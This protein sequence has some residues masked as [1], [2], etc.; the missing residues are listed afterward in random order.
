MPGAS[1]DPIRANFLSNLSADLG[2]DTPY[3]F[4][5]YLRETT[6]CKSAAGNAYSLADIQRAEGGKPAGEDSAQPIATMDQIEAAFRTAPNDKLQGT[7]ELATAILESV[8]AIDVVV[9]S[10]SAGATGINFSGLTDTLTQILDV[11]RPHVGGVDDLKSK[12]VSVD[13]KRIASEKG[14]PLTSLGGIRSR[15]DA[16]AVLAAVC[17]YFK[18]HEPSSPVPFLIERARRLLKMDFMES[19]RDMAPDSTDKF[20]ALFGLKEREKTEEKAAGS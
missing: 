16:D 15:A 3:Q 8:K 1:D 12:I 18:S 9:A 4:V 11:L 2:S 13:A 5:K 20:N 19:V 6:L 17:A 10:K 14:S 7:F